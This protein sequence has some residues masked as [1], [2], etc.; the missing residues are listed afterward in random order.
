MTKSPLRIS[1]FCSL[2][3]W[4]S[5]VVGNALAVL[6]PIDTAVARDIQQRA[7]PDHLAL[8]MLDAKHGEPPRVDQLG[9]ETVI[10]LVLV[11]DVPERVPM[12]RALH[13]KIQR[14][15]GVANLVPVLPA[16]DGVGAGGE[17]LMDRIEAAAEEARLRAAG[18]ER[19][20]EREYPARSNEL[21]CLDDFRRANVVER[22]DLIAL[23]PAAP[24]GKLLRC[25]LD[26]LAADADVHA[27]SSEIPVVMA[28]LV[29]TSRV[30][31]TCGDKTC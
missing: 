28:G 6:Q 21:C 14:V 23:A 20:A 5:L 1:T 4:S 11:E 24:V 10:G 22:A 26:R 3:H 2:A 29:S 9:V 27:N 8:G 16:G 19:N 15:V 17:H 18:V 31:P 13:A 30:Y 25:L 7:A 12:R